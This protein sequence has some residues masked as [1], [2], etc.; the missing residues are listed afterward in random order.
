[1]NLVYIKGFLWVK[2]F[3]WCNSMNPVQAI[4][5]NTVFNFK[6]GN[7]ILSHMHT[8]LSNKVFF[9]ERLVCGSDFL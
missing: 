4:W 9:F 2:S 5:I 1:M 7:S 8:V 6:R 3:E